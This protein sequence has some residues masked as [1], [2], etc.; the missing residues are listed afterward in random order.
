[1]KYLKLSVCILAA[2][3]LSV[4][5][6]GIL[7]ALS[8]QP[9][10]NTSTMFVGTIGQPKNVDP[11]QAYDT[12]SG[13]LIQ[14]VYDSIFEFGSQGT[15]TTNKTPIAA[16]TG[17]SINV[18]SDVAQLGA[19]TDISGI[20][21][22][23]PSINVLSNGSSYWTMQVDT[24]LVFQPWALPNG[25][26]E[27]G[28]HVTWQDVVYYFERL[29]VQDSHNSPEWM[30]L[31]PAFGIGN[32]DANQT[33]RGP[34]MN[35]ANETYVANLIQNF[36]TGW[37]NA[38]GQYVQFYF[39]YPP[40]GM[41]DIFCQ[42]WSSVPPMQWSILHGCWND[43][44]S[45]SPTT[46]STPYGYTQGGFET[47][48]SKAYR[49]WPSDLFT[50]LDQYTATNGQLVSGGSQYPGVGPSMCGTGPY[51]FTY[52][53]FATNEWRIDAF[54]GC[55]SHP[56]PGPYGSS[57]P[58][59][60]TVIETGI[61]T[62][63]TR[64]MEF[65]AG[66]SDI[67]VVNR[68]DMYDLLASPSNAY[69]PIAGVRLYYNIPTLQT[70]AV[71]FT[72][73]VAS[74]SQY[75]PIVNGAPDP[76]F[77]SNVLVREAFCQTL[78][79][80]AYLSGA[81]YNEA[82]QP[83]TFWAIGLTPADGYN[84]ALAPWEVNAAAVYNILYTQLGIKS[85]DITFMYNSGNSQRMIA[86]NEM[87]QTFAAI[88][89]L[90]G[91]HYTCVVSSLD[92]PTYLSDAASSELPFFMIGWLADFSDADD[93]IVPYMAT[94]GAF[95]E[96]QVFSNSTIDGLIGQEEALSA[97]PVNFTAGS[98]YE[99]RSA[100]MK[101]LQADYIQNAISLPTDQ[102]LG[103]HWSRDWVY[104]YYINQLYPGL[105]Y[106]DLYKKQSVTLTAINIDV[107]SSISTVGTTYTNVFIAG[108]NGSSTGTMNVMYGGGGAATMTF[109][110][111]VKRDDTA[112]TGLVAVEVAISRTNTT[113]LADVIPAV[114]ETTEYPTSTY[115]LVGPSGSGEVTATLS[116]YED[117]ISIIMP[118]N[119]TWQPGAYAAIAPAS[120]NVVSDSNTNDKNINASFTV[121]AWTESNPDGTYKQLVGDI[122]LDGT[123]NILDAIKLSDSF[124]LTSTQPGFIAGADLNND[125]VVN[126]LDAI[127]L[128]NHFSWYWAFP[129]VTPPPGGTPE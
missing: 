57:D 121:K 12:A 4:C 10:L 79:F 95:T 122:N 87:A 38:T 67:S 119:A 52:W 85:F 27:T 23:P 21:Y 63:A 22:Y 110:V 117:G 40:T 99:Q 41:Y 76:T 97:A 107:T 42:T 26:I 83:Y 54:A 9:P 46:F 92:W 44:F 19:A 5:V 108:T 33:A 66:D 86:V 102:P 39:I 120:A 28:E 126:I 69:N 32:F 48:W 111:G 24:N 75:I 89:S 11:S 71:F 70:D 109:N 58:A 77:F 124:L 68:A 74:S 82:I 18:S 31:G 112:Y 50:P 60:T 128:A 116:W 29:C 118:A 81:W 47:G 25:T 53:N 8:S 98:L 37:T 125:G 20:C 14:N 129:G 49:R 61:N 3:L 43:S 30:I 73:D 105:Y 55:V 106:W 45:I 115:I 35:P 51:S 34:S 64:K 7:P 113:S 16:M 6:F 17:D 56:W 1:M 13:E 59:P 88:N 62:W 104:G 84:S 101:T 36:V 90:Y 91:T 127:L 100:I 94:W 78:N 114:P 93:F 103:R 123:V 72:L 2:L 15:N 65:L 96:W 80:T